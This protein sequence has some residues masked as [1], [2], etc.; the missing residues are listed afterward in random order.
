MTTDAVTVIY[1]PTAARG[2][3][4]R[5]IGVVSAAFDRFGLPHRLE[6]SRAAGG[7]ETAVW[8]AAMGGATR[9]IVAGGDGSVHEAANGL[10]RAS[11]ETALGVVPLGTGND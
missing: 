4:A 8:Q 10:M 1:N 9:I 7:I 5:R 11:R 2:R 3:A 6:P